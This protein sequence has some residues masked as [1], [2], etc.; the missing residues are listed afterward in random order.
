[1]PAHDAQAVVQRDEGFT[2]AR[3]AA[4]GRE[5]GADQVADQARAL[6]PIGRLQHCSVVAGCIPAAV[7]VTPAARSA[8][9]ST[10]RTITCPT[11]ALALVQLREEALVAHAQPQLSGVLEHAFR[12]VEAGHRGL[13]VQL[14]HERCIPPQDR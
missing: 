6:F 10:A 5:V 3:Q 4:V 9:R 1:M 13:R 8:D 12:Q 14:A 7:E 11:A 2:A